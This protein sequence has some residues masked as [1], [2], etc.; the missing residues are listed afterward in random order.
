MDTEHADPPIPDPSIGG[1]DPLR[2]LAYAILTEIAFDP[3]LP[4]Y[5]SSARSASRRYLYSEFAKVFGKDRPTGPS[6][7]SKIVSAD[8]EGEAA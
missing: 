1:A 6:R 5:Q 4:E 7:S 3:D 8:S 2:R